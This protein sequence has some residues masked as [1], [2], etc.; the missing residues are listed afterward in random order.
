MQNTLAILL[1]PCDHKIFARC[2]EHSAAMHDSYLKYL[3]KLPLH[4]TPRP[5]LGSWHD[6]N[7]LPR[8]LQKLPHKMEPIKRTPELAVLL[9]LLSLT[10][11]WFTSRLH[12]PT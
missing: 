9:V 10:I 11:E 6:A 12:F 3:L 7:I 8:Q 1:Y 4:N 5:R 2:I